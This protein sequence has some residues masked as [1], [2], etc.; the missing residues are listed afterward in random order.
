ML[1]TIMLT[2]SRIAPDMHQPFAI[3]FDLATPVIMDGGIGLPGLLARVIADAG[4]PD[5]LPKVP[6]AATDGIF[7]GSDLFILGPSLDYHV[8][9]VRSLRPTAMAHDLAMR[10]VRG[11]RPRNQITLRDEWKNLLDAREATSATTLVAFGVGDVDAVLPLLGGLTNIGAKRSSGYGAIAAVRA[12]PIDHPHAGFADRAGNPVRPVPVDVW[13]RMNLP[14]C[15]TRN[16]VAR[17]PR[18][19]SRYEPCVGPRDWTIEAEAYECEVTG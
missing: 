14:P 15:P 13:R 6:L 3:E 7:A 1:S 12:L 16:M 9:Y 2:S 10:E 8:A 4:D 5:P 19:A 18:W 17:L 11:G